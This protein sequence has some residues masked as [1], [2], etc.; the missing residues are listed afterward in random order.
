MMGNL[1]AW[2][3]GVIDGIP[4]GLGYLSVSFSFGI[5]AATAGLHIIEAVMMSATNFTSAGQFAGVTLIA[6]SALLMEMALTQ[7]IIN[8]R[9]F[10]MSAAL[11][12]KMDPKTSMV[13]RIIMAF[14][15][16]DEVFGVSVAVKGK[17]N[18]Y[19]TYG[20]MSVALPGWT[21]GTFLGAYSGDLLPPSIV[22]A[23][24]IAL[25][26]MLLAVILPPAKGNNILSALII[27]SMVGSWLFSQVPYLQNISSGVKIILLT[28]II[29]GIAAALF[30]VKG[31]ARNG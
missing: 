27:I 17:L 21:L 12:Q 6:S 26:G 11:S 19:Y 1:A 20:V 25:Y 10:L 8:S 31:E 24:S 15:I 2:K 14:G 16:T 7:F 3:K 28:F 30:P 29:A 9:Y 22:S 18:P 5:I 23:L 4:I 13:H